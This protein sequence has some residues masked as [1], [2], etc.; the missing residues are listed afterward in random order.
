MSGR[1]CLCLCVYRFACRISVKAINLIFDQWSLEWTQLRTTFTLRFV[2]IFFSSW[3]IIFHF[4][5]MQTID[6]HICKRRSLLFTFN[7]Y[8]WIGGLFFLNRGV[9]DRYTSIIWFLQFFSSIWFGLVRFLMFLFVRSNW[10]IVM[11][12]QAEQKNHVYKENPMR[13]FR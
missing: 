3:S 11:G 2:V 10:S 4:L 13:L 7:I 12:L 9:N 6:M 1:V 5:L 8:G